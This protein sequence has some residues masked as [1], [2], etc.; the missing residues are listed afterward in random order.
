MIVTS[1]KSIALFVFIYLL[2]S[3]LPAEILLGKVVKVSDGDTITVLDS[4]NTQHRIRLLHID[5]PESKQAFGKKAKEYLASLVAGKSV[6]VEWNKKDRY[7]R[8]LGVVFFG[9]VNC[10][11]AMLIAGFAWHY[12]Q[13][14]N[15]KRLQKLED[16]AKADKMGLWSDSHA[17]AP[18][19]FR[20]RK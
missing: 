19:E 9:E 1:K 2:A 3:S 15:S 11:E 18:W 17:I 7:K 4:Q 6:K 20:K 12:K 14:S 13:Y 8:I 5:A 10:N 16:K